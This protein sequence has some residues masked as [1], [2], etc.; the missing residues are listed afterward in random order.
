MTQNIIGPIFIV[1][2]L[3][4]A[5]TAGIGLWGKLMDRES[6]RPRSILETASFFDFTGITLV[7]MLRSWS[8]KEDGAITG[9]IFLGIIVFTVGLLFQ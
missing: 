2:G 7:V 9:S 5:I 8:L 4:T 6:K 3:S 1:A